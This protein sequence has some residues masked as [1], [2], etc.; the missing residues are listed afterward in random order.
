MLLP[1]GRRVRIKTAAASVPGLTVSGIFRLVARVHRL[2]PVDHSRRGGGLAD[3]ASPI[4][5]D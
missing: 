2:M 3:P 5:S 1:C 4:D